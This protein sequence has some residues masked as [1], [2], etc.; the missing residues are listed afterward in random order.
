[1]MPRLEEILLRL[2]LA[3]VLGS[4][5]GIERERLDWAAGL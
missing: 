5:V 1:M 4:L 2:M 3:A